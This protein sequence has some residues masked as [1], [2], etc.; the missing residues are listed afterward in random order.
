MRYLKLFISFTLVLFLFAGCHVNVNKSIYIEDGETKMGN[1]ST[2]N[3]NIEIGKNCTV[4][5]SCRS[6][7]GFINVGKRSRVQTLQTVNGAIHLDEF[8]FVDGNVNTVNGHVHCKNDNVIKGDISSVNGHIEL[9]NTVVRR[10]IIVYTGNVGLNNKSTVEGDI[11]IKSSKN[12]NLEPEKLYITVTDSSVVNGDIIN[13][14]NDI[15][16][17][18]KISAGAIVKG[19][20]K[21]ATEVIRDEEI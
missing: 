12:V 14:S 3:G 18:V 19:T 4:N 2:V 20:I 17:R 16:V 6:V 10:D 9:F 11:L 15:E 5:G 7:N 1:Y 8:V 21:D 13:L